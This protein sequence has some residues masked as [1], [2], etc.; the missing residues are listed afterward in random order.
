MLFQKQQWRGRDPRHCSVTDGA[1][2]RFRAR[3]SDP[4]EQCCDTLT[5]TDA[6]GDDGVAALDPLQFV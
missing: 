3:G 4:F 1:V 2:S 5:T 6:H